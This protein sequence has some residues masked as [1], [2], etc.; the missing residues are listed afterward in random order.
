MIKKIFLLL[1]AL[2]GI[3]SFAQENKMEVVNKI[4]E[5]VKHHYA[6][7]KRVAIFHVAV[8]DTSGV[9]TLS[10]ETNIPEAKE[11][12]LADIKSAGVEVKEEIKLLPAAELEGKIYGL[13]NLS[14][15]NIRTKPDHAE[16]MSTQALLG[17]PVKIFKKAHGYFLVQTP[18]MY[19]SW[20]EDDGVT[21][22]TKPEFEEWINSEKIV[23]L[24][25]FGFSYSKPDAGS[26]R[27]SDLVAGN[28]LVKIGEGGNFI[29]VKYPDGR[30]AFV[31]KEFCMNYKNWLERKMP[32][33][34]NIISTAEKFMGIPYLWGGTSAKGMDC[35]GFT[36]TVYFLNGIVLV[37]DASQ[38]VHNGVLVDTQNGFENLQPGDLL[39]FGTQA[40]DSTKERVT[41]VAIY[42]GNYEFIHAAG[43]IKINS[44][45]RNTENF[46]EYRLNHFI[47]ARRILNSVEE[48]GIISVKKHKFYLGEF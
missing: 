41:H 46:S 27:V 4:I 25:E 16:E 44:F 15:A 7:D 31:E 47:R 37:R 10:G 2:F 35:S 36:K 5:E 40:T 22:L 29:K 38:Q 39:F 26:I 34:A 33:S 12:L 42:Y 32:T 24:K 14:V 3:A 18:D 20:V 30:I 17:T 8:N 13:V 9:I 19:I 1:T 28:I 21:P 11:K 6:P 45:D 23:Y 48:N 43:R